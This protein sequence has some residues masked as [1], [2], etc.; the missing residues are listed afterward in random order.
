MGDVS[1]RKYFRARQL[2]GASL[3]VAWYPAEARES[4]GRYVRATRLLARAGI[5]TPEILAVDNEQA[6]MALEDVG[7]RRLF[8]LEPGPRTE[9]LLEQATRIAGRLATLPSATVA[10]LN[11]PLD[12][13][14]MQRELDQT[15]RLF[16][17]RRLAGVT[18]DRFRDALDE[19]CDAI[20]AEPLVPCHRDLMCRNLMV[21]GAS[22]HEEL[23]VLDHQD[24]RLGPRSY[25][26]ASLLHDSCILAPAQIDQ[27]EE[28]WTEICAS[29]AYHR[30]VVQ[31]TLKI[32][33]TFHAFAERGE[34]LYLPMVPRALADALHHLARLPGLADLAL[35]LRGPLLG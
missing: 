16:L 29:S 3:V 4:Y 13:A 10:E 26:L 30:L 24:L 18:R 35:E 12:R 31:R 14:L 25:D 5:R 11:P 21:V 19:L 27:L 22:P 34:P 7:D 6:F 15:W 2:V 17:T 8:D 23:V 20:A 9:A 33:G 1:S 28:R 32:V